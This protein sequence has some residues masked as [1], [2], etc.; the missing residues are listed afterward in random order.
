MLESPAPSPQEFGRRHYFPCASDAEW[1]D[2]RWQYRHRIKD[3]DT[4]LKYLP[5]SNADVK[6]LRLLEAQLHIGIPPYYLSLIDPSDPE[7]PIRKQAAPSVAEFSSFC[8]GMNDPLAEDR[9]MPV[10]GL[11]HRYPDRCLFIAT[12]M[13]PMYCRHCTRRREWEDGEVPKGRPM[14]D[15]MI[16]YIRDSPSIRDVIFSGGDPLSL[17]IPVLDYCLSELRKIPHVEIIRI[18]TRYPVVLPQRI[19]DDLLSVLERHL[20]IWL[21]THFNHP[22][23]LTPESAAACRRISRAGIPINNQSVLMRGVNDST[24][25]MLKLCQGLLK[26]G[27]RPYYLFQCDPIQG[28]EHLRTNAWTGVEILEKMRGHTSGLAIPT[29]VVDTEGGGKVPLAPNYLMYATEESLVV[30]NYE[31]RIFNYRNP[32]PPP[33]RKT[34]KAA[35]LPFDQGAKPA[36]PRLVKRDKVPTPHANRPGI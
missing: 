7:D 17:A 4:L 24:E 30:R 10:E 12:N 25:T 28:A 33:Q 15:T 5:Y 27:V 31:G 36:R 16:A 23:E 21:N 14:L 3:L 32:S 9:A 18:A 6:Q 29:F 11:V 35:P 1:N 8:M 26:M 34:R 13:C 2:W 22:N 20:P 19:T